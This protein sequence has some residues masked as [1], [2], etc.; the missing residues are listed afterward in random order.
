MGV[1]IKRLRGEALYRRGKEFKREVVDTAIDEILDGEHRV[2]YILHKPG[3]GVCLIAQVSP[4]VEAQIKRAVAERDQQ[5]GWMEP[6]DGE[7]KLSKA[8]IVPEELLES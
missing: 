8:P 7:R 1:T 5:L 2:G 6:P 4:S 3:A